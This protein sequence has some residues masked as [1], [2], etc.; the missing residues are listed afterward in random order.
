[1]ELT[2]VL[3]DRNVLKH[4]GKVAK[5]TGKFLKDAALWMGHAI[6]VLFTDYLVPGMKAAWPYISAAAV[7]VGQAIISPIGLG[8]LALATGIAISAGCFALSKSQNLKGK[9]YRMHRWT[10]QVTAIFVA[11]I[12]GA[13]FATGVMVGIG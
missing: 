12:G 5:T 7:A 6:K 3:T 9:E 13:L 4:M 11:A 2:A 8:T 1:M 10:L